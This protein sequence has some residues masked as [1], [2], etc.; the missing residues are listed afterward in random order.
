MEQQVE[1]VMPDVQEVTV[2]PKAEY[3]LHIK[4][5]EEMRGA[6][7]DAAELAYRLGNIPKPDLVDLMNLFIGYGMSVLKRQWLD[8]VGYR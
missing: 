5:P 7:R 1:E 4:V 8:R 6:L 2:Q 3:D